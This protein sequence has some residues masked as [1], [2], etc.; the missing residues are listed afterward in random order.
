M[1]VI[2]VSHIDPPDPI[3]RRFSKSELSFLEL[4]EQIKV[5]GAPFQAPPARPR[6]NSRYQLIDGYRRFEAIKVANIDS[7]PLHVVDLDDKDYLSAQMACNALCKD[8]DWWDYAEHLERLR[9]MG[10][11]E[12]SLNELADAC[13]RSVSWVRKI[14]SLNNLEKKYASMLR[15]GELSVG[16][17][18]WLSKLPKHE[19]ENFIE[20]ALSLST[21]D[22]ENKM[23]LVIQDRK[24]KLKQGRILAASEDRFELRMRKLDEIEAEINNPSQLPALITSEGVSDPLDIATL[25]LKWAF[26]TDS[27]SIQERQDKL[28]SYEIQNINDIERR[29]L[30]RENLKNSA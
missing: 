9:T 13:Q 29:R 8:V 25:A 1:T 6:P 10:D 15:G 23:K 12:M 24:E 11:T 20:D 14:L 3:L 17:G 5:H 7:M 19:Q 16:N 22:F 2:P 28:L 30:E 27:V 21:R 4:V 26:C 18:S